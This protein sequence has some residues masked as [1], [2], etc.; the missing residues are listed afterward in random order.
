MKVTLGC[1]LKQTFLC[2]Y[3]IPGNQR[4]ERTWLEVM[5]SDRN[6]GKSRV[7]QSVCLTGL[8]AL[9]GCQEV[10][11]FQGSRA[12][13]S[14]D[15]DGTFLVTGKAAKVMNCAAWQGAGEEAAVFF[16]SGGG[17]IAGPGGWTATFQNDPGGQ[18][19]VIVRDASAEVD[20]ILDQKMRNWL[21]GCPEST[22]PVLPGMEQHL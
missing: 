7:V 3:L 11:S 13:L 2:P 14:T 17:K 6:A 22:R 1:P 15:N 10:A 9:I 20:P 4:F 5:M 21:Q 16:G 19:R 12:G 18:T 8:A